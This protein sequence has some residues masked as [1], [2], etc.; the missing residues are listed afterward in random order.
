MSVPDVT[1]LSI[2]EAV[3]RLDQWAYGTHYDTPEAA[4]VRLVL[5]AMR[6]RGYIKGTD[7]LHF[8]ACDDCRG[9]HA[10]HCPVYPLGASR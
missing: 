7:C 2:K 10:R 8:S 3:R 6:E 5:L 4:D 9:V 1:G